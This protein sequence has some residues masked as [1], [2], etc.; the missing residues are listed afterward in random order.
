[1]LDDKKSDE[2]SSGLDTHGMETNIYFRETTFQMSPAWTIVTR[3]ASATS[4]QLRKREVRPRNW[5]RQE[6]LPLD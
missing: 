3:E 2:K 6:W 5:V 4:R 1:M